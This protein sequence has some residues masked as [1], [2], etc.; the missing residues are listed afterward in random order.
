MTDQKI[1]ATHTPTP[2]RV[3]ENDGAYVKASYLARLRIETAPESGRDLCLALVITDTS[4]LN[5]RA[6]ADFIVRAVNSHDDLLEALKAVT[7]TLASWTADH[8]FD[9][10]AHIDAVLAV[11]NAA[12]SKAEGR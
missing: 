2:W 12:I 4:E 5:N 10:T 9:C 1:A 3:V 11:A 7:E 6:N 8:S